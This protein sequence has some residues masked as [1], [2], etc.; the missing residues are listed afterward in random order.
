MA[1]KVLQSSGEKGDHPGIAAAASRAMGAGFPYAVLEHLAEG[2]VL[3]NQTGRITQW[4]RA[5]ESITGIARERSLGRAVWEIY[6]AHVEAAHP[7]TDVSIEPLV[8]ALIREA[9]RDPAS[10]RLRARTEFSWWRPDGETRM[11]RADMFALGSQDHCTLG[12]LVNDVTDDR[13]TES[14]LRLTQLSVDQAADLIHWITSDGRLL[15]VSDS[16]CGR[17][18]YSREELLNMTIFDL[19]PF[20]TPEGWDNLWGAICEQG[21]IT[22]EGVHRTKSG[23]MFPIEVVGN[24]VLHDGC[25]YNFAYGRDITERKL[26][27]QQ[28][29]QA[30]ED[31]ER[32]NRELRE[33]TRIAEEATLQLR[34]MN[35]R[36]L[37]TQEALAIQA[38]TDSLTGSFNRGAVL[39]RLDALL[40]QADRN[41]SGLGVSM[42]DIDHFKHVNDTYGHQ[43]GDLVL[44]EVA[45]RCQKT[46]RPYDAFGRFGG[47]EFLAV[48]PDTDE[49]SL[50]LVLERLRARIAEK[51]IR[52]QTNDIAVTVSIGGTVGR[53]TSADAL[54]S[55]ADAALYLA[56]DRGRNRLEM[57]A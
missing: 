31:L 34:E 3:V 9:V 4:N 39:G 22:V 18:G 36:L 5:M 45:D 20:L 54:I 38:R 6:D 47:E 52:V 28:L 29:H 11:L 16:N 10:P 1:V 32:S 41:N 7:T 40:A 46:L 13:R 27:E 2:L 43:A 30:T 17:H 8:R 44:R 23:E 42:I 53:S 35:E 48:V 25:E 57:S 21:S 51:P 19:D 15:Y 33:A 49:E 14:A 12:Y 26:A 37:Q 56:K 50:R 24:Y 55:R